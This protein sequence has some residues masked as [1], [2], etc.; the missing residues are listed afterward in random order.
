MRLRLLAAAATI[1]LAAP[2]A[3]RAEEPAPECPPALACRWAPA[4]YR[5]NGADPAHYGNYDLAARP[6]DGLAIRY[7]VIHDTEVEHDAAIRIFQDPFS[8]VSAHYLVRSAN[9]R[10]TQLV[11]NRDVAWHAGNWWLNSHAIGIEAEGFAVEGRTWYSDALYRSLARLTRWLARRYDVPLDRAHVIGHDEVPGPTAKEQP[12]MHWDPGPFFDWDRFMRLAGADDED[13]DNDD[14]GRLDR[15]P[16]IAT[17]APEFERNRPAITTCDR[18]PCRPL[19]SQP[20]NVVFLHTAPRADAPLIGD[21]L[22]ARTPVE[23]DGVG[24][25]R[26]E[27]WGA[28][29][30]TGQKFAVAGRRRGWTAIWFAGREAWFRNPGLANT[31]PGRGTLVTPRAG[32]A[33]VPVYGRAYPA[34]VSSEPLG[35]T[36][37]A[38]QIYVAH[39]AVGADY[40]SAQAFNAP[41]TYAV[42]KDPERFYAISFNHRLSFVRAADV[43]RVPASTDDR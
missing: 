28:T 21:P 6:R 10:V 36:I 1:A 41:Q 40:Y 30:V 35:Y 32:L 15:D 27:D 37:P 25:T 13:D 42:V 22:L 39:G 31:R 8:A 23:P 2:Q 34:S 38:G 4:A 29:A 12:A 20:A 18:G 17:I 9:G 43:E 33:A 14:R 19:P 7:I 26:A 24:T 11:R 16:R 3:A 5:Q